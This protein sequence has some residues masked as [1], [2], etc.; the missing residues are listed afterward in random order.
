MIWFDTNVPRGNARPRPPGCRSGTIAAD[1][2][3]SPRRYGHSIPRRR[4]RRRRRGACTRPGDHE[5]FEPEGLRP[6]HGLALQ[7]LVDGSRSSRASTRPFT[8]KKAKAPTRTAPTTMRRRRCLAAG[9]WTSTW[10]VQR[11]RGRVALR[12]GPPA[13]R[14]PKE[15]GRRRHFS[16]F[17]RSDDD[18]GRTV[19]P[20]GVRVDACGPGARGDGGRHQQLPGIGAEHGQGDAVTGVDVT[21]GTSSAGCSPRARD[22]TCAGVSSSTT[23]TGPASVAPWP[24]GGAPSAQRSCRAISSS[25]PSRTSDSTLDAVP[26]HQH[27]DEH[28]CQSHETEKQRPRH[29]AVD[30]GREIRVQDRGSLM[31]RLPPVDREVDDGNIHAG[32]HGTHRAPPGSG[33][34]VTGDPS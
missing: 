26:H 8:N 12:R 22:P 1:C 34:G 11:R 23:A 27:P 31:Q 21:H 10:P 17:D 6:Q 20:V 3:C 18:R 28:Q 2:P 13:R 19:H 29:D 24:S 25:A 32:D 4:S 5:S 15:A 16:S 7:G 30:G 14:P 9:R 33:V